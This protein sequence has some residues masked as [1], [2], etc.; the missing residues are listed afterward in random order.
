MILLLS[1]WDK[2]IKKSKPNL[3]RALIRAYW[4]Q[5]LFLGIFATLEV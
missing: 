5:I 1:E 4:K 2:E 3:T